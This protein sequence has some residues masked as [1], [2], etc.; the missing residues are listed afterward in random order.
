MKEKKYQLLVNADDFGR[1]VLINRAVAE[2]VERGILRSATLMPGGKAFDGAVET[3]LTHPE[4]GVGV[5]FTLVNGFPVLPPE[6]IP[7]LVT[8]E[9]VFYDDYIHFVKRFLAGRVRMEEVRRELAAQAEKMAKTGLSLT[10]VDGHQHMHVLP[11]I[12]DAALD[13]AEAV[14]ID[15]VRIPKAPLFEASSGSLGQLVGR[16]GLFTLAEA[17]ERRA[18]IRGFR[19]PDHFAGIVAGEAVSEAHFRHIVE[20]MKPGATEVMMHPGTDNAV[21][22]R[23]CLW[24]HD[25]E[26]ELAA[27]TSPEIEKLLDEKDIEIINFNDLG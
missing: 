1:H 24:V 6:E 26:A 12:F 8:G 3:A 13:A 14:H 16:L 10:H 25:F 22:Q 18:K 2:G 21:L 15:A 23:D 5:H 11:G 20:T 9:G 27:I 7:S 4:L 17:A 19:T